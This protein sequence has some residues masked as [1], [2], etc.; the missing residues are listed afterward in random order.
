[1]LDLNNNRC[2]NVTYKIVVTTS[3]VVAGK[4]VALGLT[5]VGIGE[6]VHFVQ[7]VEINVS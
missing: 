1:M 5:D 6:A 2:L 7:I 4:G 3:V